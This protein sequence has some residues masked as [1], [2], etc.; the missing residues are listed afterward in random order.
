MKLHNK[1]WLK[2]ITMLFAGLG[3]LL[4]V[5]ACSNEKKPKYLSE[6]APNVSNLLDSGWQKYSNGD[7]SGAY[8]D[9]SQASQRD[10]SVP[11]VY[12]G[13]GFAS[14]QMG[15]LD[16]AESNFSKTISFA[17]FDSANADMLIN[18]ANAGLSM[19]YLA[20]KEYTNSIDAATLVINNDPQFKFQFDNAI[21]VDDIYLTRA[22]SSFHVL[23]FEQAYYDVIAVNPDAD[24]SSVVGDSTTSNATISSNTRNLTSGTAQFTLSK[25]HIV[26]VK[27]VQMVI[28]TNRTYK[29]VN[30]E[31]GG[32]TATIF[33]NP[34]PT[35][36]QAL[37][38]S[39][40]NAPDYGKFL[41]TLMNE[42][43]HL[44]EVNS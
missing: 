11:K 26:T 41:D 18:S 25:Q 14:F 42:I 20:K 6:P 37:E 43:V 2:Q 38:V 12:L 33:G 34:L 40:V 7:F 23:D 21:T 35:A 9:F 10:A 17:I 28:N 8:D 24:F 19:T 39:Y 22:L 29:V 3:L 30:F 31:Q 1:V 16:R 13:M 44:R 5:T 4:I 36:S 27:S 32:A 15:N